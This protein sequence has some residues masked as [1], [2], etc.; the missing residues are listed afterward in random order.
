M[1]KFSY[2]AVS[3][4]KLL[5][6]HPDLR[7]V[8]GKA[9]GYGVVD[10]SIIWGWRN[11]EAQ[12]QMVR[13]VPPTST[14]LFPNSYHNAM[15]DDGNPLS[16]AFDFAPW[17]NGSIP[18]HDEKA[19]VLVGGLMLAAAADLDIGVTYGGDWDRDG[20]I[21]EHSLGDFGHIQRIR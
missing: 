4:R 10:I 13:N 2:G 21:E 6:C 3:K 14:K 16:D 19:F 17:I 15:D 11:E 12:N 18:W 20:L 9:L 8:A 1:S 5:S 7:A